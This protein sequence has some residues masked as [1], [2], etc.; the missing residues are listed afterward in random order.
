MELTAVVLH[1]GVWAQ[2]KIVER[3]QN[4]FTACLLS[5]SGDPAT[6]PPRRVSMEKIG[7]HCVGNIVDEVLMDD[8]YYAAKEELAK[9]R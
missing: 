7:R 3:E 6:A 2:Y 1:R 8:L 9:R 5:Y 4:R